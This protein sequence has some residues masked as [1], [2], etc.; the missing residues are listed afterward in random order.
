[1][2]EQIFCHTSGVGCLV[3]TISTEQQKRDFTATALYMFLVQLQEQS[4]A[5]IKMYPHLTSR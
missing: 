3:L 5:A 2:L 4:L 1:M